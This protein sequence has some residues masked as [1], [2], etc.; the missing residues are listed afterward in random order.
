MR[1]TLNNLFLQFCNVCVIFDES[2]LNYKKKQKKQKTAWR[3]GILSCFYTQVSLYDVR[4]TKLV[5]KLLWFLLRIWVKGKAMPL[6]K[7]PSTSE[8]SCKIKCYIFQY[9]Y[10]FG[11]GKQLLKARSR[12]ALS[13][14]AWAEGIEICSFEEQQIIG[15]TAGKWK[16]QPPPRA[17]RWGRKVR[18]G[19]RNGHQQ[20]L[21]QYWVRAERGCRETL[22]LAASWKIRIGRRERVKKDEYLCTLMGELF[23]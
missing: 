16:Q 9:D 20:E 5:L 10:F 21:Q 8:I 11:W 3:E 18:S 17:S 1:N 7:L 15:F 22:M 14:A 4:W 19:C 6:P 23:L 2:F 12:D 13:G